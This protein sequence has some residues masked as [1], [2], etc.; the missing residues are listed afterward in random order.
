MARPFAV[1]WMALLTAASMLSL[2]GMAQAQSSQAPAQS[3]SQ[4]AA[5]P[6]QAP[7]QSA[8]GAPDPASNQTD[9]SETTKS[10]PAKSTAAKPVTQKDSPDVKTGSKEDV[11]A[12]GN[13]S[14]GKGLD[15]YSL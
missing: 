1:R 4:P 15:F 9:S 8:D 2:P 5:A 13:R 10:A 3:P 7:D 14:V 6:A 12:I 11:D